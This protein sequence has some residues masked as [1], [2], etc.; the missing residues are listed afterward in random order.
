VRAA[1][2][3]RAATC[4]NTLKVVEVAA[5]APAQ[6]PPTS[7]P[8]R[9]AAPAPSSTGPPPPD[10]KRYGAC[11]Q[12]AFNQRI[13]EMGPDPLQ[14]FLGAIDDPP[15]PLAAGPVATAAGLVAVL[16]IVGTALLS[17]RVL[18]PIAALTSASQRL[19][20][21]DLG[22]RVPVVGRDE[23]A[24]LARSFNRMADSLQRG[25][26]RQ[27]RM[28]ADVAHELRT[29][30]A[31]LR[32]Y[33]EALKDE[34]MQP[35]PALF[36]SLHEEAVLQQR[37]VDDLQDLALVEAGRLVYRRTG[38]DVV[39]LLETC[40]VGHRAV[41]DAAG[42]RL[43]V[44]SGPSAAEPLYVHAD[45]DRMRQV[46]GNL[47]SNAVRATA[48][49]GTVTLAV[50]GNGATHTVTVTVTD[51]GTGIAPT[52]LPHIF[53]RFWRAD[54]ARGR[55]TGGT[56]LGLAITQHIVTDHGGTIRVASTLGVGTAFTI[57]LPAA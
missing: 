48:P 6:A 43:V 47:V 28:V 44:S 35:D 34:V 31:N 49:G 27:R 52:D 20:E 18:R 12:D 14:V 10:P 53:D 22:E 21:G 7:V 32:G 50:L 23:L 4:D 33:L 55:T 15:R 51:T 39:E 40:R 46:V 5:S 24:E 25:E 8:Q 54:A 13:S 56:G 1:D 57:T 36:A 38:I 37:I 2:T 26:E 16:A 9:T 30:L 3:E 42:V 11:L 29:P 19:G 41:A 45:S 17:R